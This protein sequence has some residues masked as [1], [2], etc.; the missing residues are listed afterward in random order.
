ML[1]IRTLDGLSLPILHARKTLSTLIIVDKIVLPMRWGQ[2]NEYSLH[3]PVGRSW[4]V[5]FSQCR[6]D[7]SV[8]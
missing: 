4:L 6:Q 2:I 3:L 5:W 1:Q 8:W 7:G